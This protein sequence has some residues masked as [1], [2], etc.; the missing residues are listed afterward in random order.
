ML[1]FEFRLVEKN[2]YTLI[3]LNLNFLDTSC[4]C[5]RGGGKGNRQGQELYYDMNIYLQ[6]H[7]TYKLLTLVVV[8][9]S[10]PPCV[11]LTLVFSLL[12]HS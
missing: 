8:V 7:T 12:P 2:D 6:S 5:R 4:H 10:L 9:T 11:S 3:V 1:L